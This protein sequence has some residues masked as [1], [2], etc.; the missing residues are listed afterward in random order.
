MFRF[1]TDKYDFWPIY[2]AIKRFYPIGIRGINLDGDNQMFLSYPGLKELEAIIVDN[3]HNESHFAERWSNFT[4]EI[5][6]ETGKEVIGTTYGQAPSFS[7][8]VLLEKTSVDNLTRTKEIHFFVSLVGPFYTVIG[9]DTSTVLRDGKY[10]YRGTNYLVVSPEDEFADVFKR[11]CAKI[12]DR[13]KGYRFVPFEIC[14]QTITGL[15]V[16]YSDE[17]LDAI[18]HA[19]FNNS[20]N[21]TTWNWLGN[22]YYKSADWIKEGWKGSD[23]DWIIYPP[24][25][26]N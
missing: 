18:F 25:G 15:S 19:L 10:H 21:L 12:E 20:L 8:F 14:K 9:Q 3:I 5:Q 24:L 11:I 16:R 2:E 23:G 17:K 13:F 1:N 4:Q 6:D 22:D 7:S 26:S